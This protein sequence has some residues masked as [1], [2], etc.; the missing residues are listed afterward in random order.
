[1]NRFCTGTDS[2]H[3]GNSS[4]S[5]RYCHCFSGNNLSESDLNCLL[6]LNLG[7]KSDFVLS[8]SFHPQV[9]LLSQCQ[10]PAWCQPYKYATAPPQSAPGQQV[11]AS[12]LLA[13][14][15]KATTT[16]L[17]LRECSYTQAIFWSSQWSHWDARLKENTRSRSRKW[18]MNGNYWQR[19]PQP[20]IS[21]YSLVQESCNSGSGVWTLNWNSIQK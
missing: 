11:S 1:M 18:K 7:P 16:I 2:W 3:L 10:S 6:T 21:N 4:A 20:W 8:H 19:R 12:T 13:E 15:S 5:S 9:C 17:S 14:P